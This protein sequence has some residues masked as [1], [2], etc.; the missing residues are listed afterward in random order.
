MKQ[1]THWNTDQRK[2]IMPN[3]NKRIPV[4]A[5]TSVSNLHQ[6][7]FE[8]CFC[9]F[10]FKVKHHSRLISLA[11][12]HLR[13]I[14]LPVNPAWPFNYATFSFP[15]QTTWARLIVMQSLLSP[16]YIILSF[17]FFHAD[18]Q[19]RFLPMVTLAHWWFKTLE[20]LSP[21]CGSGRGHHYSWRT[22]E[23][24]VN[25]R[26]RRRR[27]RGTDGR[28]THETE[29]K[30]S[31]DRL[32]LDPF[33]ENDNKSSWFIKVHMC[34]INHARMLRNRSWFPPCY[35]SLHESPSPFR[36]CSESRQAGKVGGRATLFLW[37]SGAC[38]QLLAEARGCCLLL[39]QNHSHILE[40][41]ARISCTHSR[42]RKRPQ[43]GLTWNKK[44]ALT[45]K[46][47]CLLNLSTCVN[48]WGIPVWQRGVAE[49]HDS[50]AHTV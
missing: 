4:E 8:A 20:D 44:T 46:S 27:K 13:C 18:T 32:L 16:V 2:T 5:L 22:M 19:T 15:W 47:Q 3:Q 48:I 6:E 40:E 24:V 34:K 29:T 26:L 30:A 35:I 45:K 33:P 21:D 25:R 41:S 1:I 14:S 12:S 36:A 42:P 23:E 9:L 49:T 38:W 43:T 31:T 28:R 10:P 37:F 11:F 7:S 50:Q 17:C 39:G